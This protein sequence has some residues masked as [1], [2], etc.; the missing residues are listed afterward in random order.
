MKH[1][2]PI[3]LL[4]TTL[5]SG[6]T[7]LTTTKSVTD[8]H[9]SIHV[10]HV[11]GFIGYVYETITLTIKNEKIHHS[12]VVPATDIE[13]IQVTTQP[14]DEKVTYSGY[15]DL[16]EEDQVEIRLIEEREDIN[17]QKYYHPIALN[18]VFKYD[19]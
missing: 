6:C 4:A 3:L 5:N 9:T 12:G 15:I 18:G 1:L 7:T 11:G 16:S 17:G 10:K 19:E 13:D 8:S 2:L 14:I